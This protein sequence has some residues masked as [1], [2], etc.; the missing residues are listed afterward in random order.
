V[1]F[2]FFFRGAKVFLKALACVFYKNE[3]AFK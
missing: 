2:F 3:N 1:F